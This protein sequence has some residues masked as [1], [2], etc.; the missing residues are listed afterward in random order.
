[1]KMLIAL[2][3]LMLSPLCYSEEEKVIYK[4]KKYEKFDLGS[5]EIKGEVIAPG[6]LSVM[7]RERKRFTRSFYERTDFKQDMKNEM[8]SLR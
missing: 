6:D 2:I 3:C 8:H 1:M 4:Y 5:L 7:E